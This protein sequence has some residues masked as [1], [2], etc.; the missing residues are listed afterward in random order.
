MEKEMKAV[1]EWKVDRKN[2]KLD[3]YEQEIEDSWTPENMKPISLQEKL[4]EQFR[5]AA[6]KYN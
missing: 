3:P 4:L 5:E 6:K 1:K 2:L